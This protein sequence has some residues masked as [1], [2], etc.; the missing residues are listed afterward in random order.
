MASKIVRLNTIQ[1]MFNR[2]DTRPTAI[3]IHMW[4]DEK[5]KIRE[6]DIQ[7]LQLVAKQSSVFVKFKTPELY[8]Q[9]LQN[10]SGTHN[11]QLMNG[12]INKVKVG[13]AEHDYVTVRVLNVPPEIPN[14]RIKNVLN[15]YGKVQQ[16][17][18]ETWANRYKYNVETGI[19]IVKMSIDKHIPTSLTISQ[20]EAYITYIGQEQ[21]CYTCGSS[22]H[23]RTNCPRRAQERLTNPTRNKKLMSDLF[24]TTAEIETRDHISIEVDRD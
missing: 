14:D 6:Q 9:Y 11:F 3:E 24:L 21:T 18:N 22:Q 10:H 7:T 4:L 17:E 8:E 19:R 16:I 2:E 12:S 1:I 23:M 13:P 5:L 15:N 20:Y